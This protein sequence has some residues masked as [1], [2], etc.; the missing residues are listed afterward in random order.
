MPPLAES[1]SLAVL[2]TVGLP[3]TASAALCGW[4]RHYALARA[5]LD[6]PN[7]RSSHSAATPRGGGVAIV[8]VA[9]AGLAYTALAGPLPP[10]PTV[11][12]LLA[13]FVV[14]TVGW[15]DD[16]WK[17]AAGWRFLGHLCGSAMA[18]AALG[19]VSVLVLGEFRLPLSWLGAAGSV[20]GV[21]YLINVTNFMDG[22]DGIA[23]TESAF[24]CAAMALFAA[25]DLGIPAAVAAAACAGFLFWNWPPARLF[26]GDVGSGFL[27]FMM[28]ILILDCA[29][30]HPERLW[31]AAILPGAF[32]V[33]G[34]LTLARRI[35]NGENW[36]QAHRGHAY[37][38]AA[39]RW[40]HRTV[41]LA[42][43]ALDL[44]WL[45]PLAL[46]AWRRPS[47]GAALLVLS[48][49]PLAALALWQR[50]GQRSVYSKQVNSR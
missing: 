13:A 26:M 32:V 31:G 39:L 36:T 47:H 25:S 38:H 50:A 4:Y 42:F 35:L 24:V 15:W 27:G 48:W 43:M 11:A 23:A 45:L 6:L 14:A 18:V 5:I 9:M 49:L 16:R 44:L 33:D 29:A 37:Q 21:T 3:L 17:L 40:G 20:L 7:E 41:T 19:A 8:G 46:L 22:I 10:R 2:A 34:T 1:L 30:G 28:G 12:L